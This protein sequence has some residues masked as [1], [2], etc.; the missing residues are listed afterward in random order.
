MLHCKCARCGWTWRDYRAAT[1]RE[2][3]GCGHCGAA[4]GAGYGPYTP[5]PRSRPPADIWQGMPPA[6]ALADM[7]AA[8]LARRD[9]R[10]SS[11]P[12]RQKPVQKPKPRQ[13]TPTRKATARP[14]GGT[15]ARRGARAS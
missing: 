4:W 11:R 5:G 9:A 8:R 6:E 14:T 15:V 1:I 2:R 7:L 10:A 13:K 3:V 12:A